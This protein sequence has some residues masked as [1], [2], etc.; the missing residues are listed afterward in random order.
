[1]SRSDLDEAH[2][3]RIE[4]DR[5]PAAIPELVRTIRQLQHD[6]DALRLSL[7]VVRRDREELRAELVRA[8]GR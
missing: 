5:D 8:R 4:R 6:L 1:M 2:L 7:E 3:D